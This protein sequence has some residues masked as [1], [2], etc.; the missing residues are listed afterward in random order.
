MTGSELLSHLQSLSSDSLALPIY[1]RDEEWQERE[2]TH[3]KLKRVEMEPCP[4]IILDV[5]GPVIKKF[6][7]PQ[8]VDFQ[9]GGVVW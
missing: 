2:I 1:G 6:R 4:V 5:K 7:P 9:R 3:I 8:P